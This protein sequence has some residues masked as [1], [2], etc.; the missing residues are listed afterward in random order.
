MKTA[1]D[2]LNQPWVRGAV[3]LAFGLVAVIWA[4]NYFSPEARVR[5][6]TARVVALVQKTGDESPVALGV[7]ANRFG[8]LLGVNATLEIDD[9]G[10]IVSQRSEIVQMFLQVRDTFK[11]VSLM[12]PK[13]ATT[14]K[15]GGGVTAFVSAHYRFAPIND[16]V[17]EGDGNATL[18]WGKNDEGWQIQHA[19]LHPDP[20]QTLPGGWR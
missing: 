15:K 4:L 9:W 1:D 20:H 10:V 8:D 14:V 3:L 19:V 6:A 2:G 17:I 18:Q 12:E 5:R 16:Q 7:T 11:R 13:I